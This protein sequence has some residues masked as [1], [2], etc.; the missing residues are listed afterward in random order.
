MN[1][2]V[3]IGRHRATAPA[4]YSTLIQTPEFGMPLLFPGVTAIS[5]ADQIL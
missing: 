5:A 4:L 1:L 2:I 3:S